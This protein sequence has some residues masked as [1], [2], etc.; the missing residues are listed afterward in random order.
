MGSFY[1]RKGDDGYTDLLGAGRI[2][3]FHPQPSAYGAIDEAVSALGLAKAFSQSE[4][5]VRIAERIQ[6]DLYMMMAEIASTPEN[7]EKFPQIGLSRIE[8]L[9]G[10]IE[11][12]ESEVELPKEFILPGDSVAGA[13]FDLARTIVRRA[14]RQVAKLTLEGGFEFELPMR[15]LNRLS[16]LCFILTLWEN[17]QAGFLHPTLAKDE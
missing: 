13:F 12:L 10:E 7:R 17:T 4:R 3:K 2:P 15:Y 6:R 16:S 8:W 5:S 14:E 9:E 11:E 1:T